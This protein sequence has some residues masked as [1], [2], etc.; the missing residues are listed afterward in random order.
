MQAKHSLQ[1]GARVEKGAVRSHLQYEC[2]KSS[3]CD[4]EKRILRSFQFF[5]VLSSKASRLHDLI[6]RKT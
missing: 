4:A 2:L 5:D 6:D 3:T 1:N